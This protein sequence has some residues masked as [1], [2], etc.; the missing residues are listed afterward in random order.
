[1]QTITYRDFEEFEE[2]GIVLKEAWDIQALQGVFGLTLAVSGTPSSSEIIV[3]ATTGCGST[4]FD[5]LSQTDW[6]FTGGSIDSSAY[7][8]STGLYT[9]G[10]TGLA[11]GN[12]STGGVITIG[13]WLYE[14]DVLAVTI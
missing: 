6:S 12:L 13:S 14:S 11:S 10:G 5:G 1:M 3:K 9:L 2:N 4:P 7:N 8:A